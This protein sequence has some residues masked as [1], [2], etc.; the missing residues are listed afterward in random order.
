MDAP[1]MFTR[2]IQ[3]A[4]ERR[5]LHAYLR[6]S[7][8]EQLN[9]LGLEVQRQ[10]CER[11][12]HQ[13]DVGIVNVYTDEGASGTL[14]L[15]A[16]QGLPKLL[17]SLAMGE[18]SGILV[19]R[20]D[21]LARDMILQEAILKDLW[22]DGY[23]V[24]S[25]SEAES[26]MLAGDD[27]ADPARK[28]IR[29]IMGAVSEYERSLVVMRMN[30]GKQLKAAQGGYIGGKAPYGWRRPKPN[31]GELLLMEVPAEQ[32]AITMMI[33]KR[34]EGMGYRDISAH[35]RDHGHLNR[36]SVAF[37]PASVMKIV[38]ANNEGRDPKRDALLGIGS[39]N[40]SEGN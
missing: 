8:S 31:L 12:A 39:N 24:A 29:Q 10:A 3:P 32:E 9:G 14:A 1:S 19:Y 17:S 13:N 4:P 23:T 37:N 18:A 26:D 2:E 7:T 28:L 27:K 36:R 6:V 20:M 35:L 30:A 25:C 34:R 40:A 38:K 16:R 33:A 11:W 15:E 21:R 22:A 5:R